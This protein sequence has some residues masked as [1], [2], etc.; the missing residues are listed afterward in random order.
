MEDELLNLVQSDDYYSLSE[1]FVWKQMR[2]GPLI[3]KESNQKD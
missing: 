1:E 2:I 3:F